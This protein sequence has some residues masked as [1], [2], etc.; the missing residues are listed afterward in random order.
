MFL[1][2]NQNGS[3]SSLTSV[4]LIVLYNIKVIFESRYRKFAA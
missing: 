2:A 3:V 1:Y 4:T